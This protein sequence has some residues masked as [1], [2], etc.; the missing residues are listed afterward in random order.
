MAPSFDQ[1]RAA[2]ESGDFSG[3]RSLCL[4]LVESTP[5]AAA[6]QVLAAAE[7]ALGD[8]GAARRALEAAAGLAPDDPGPLIGLA[9][10]DMAEGQAEAAVVRLR[11]VA[12]L[13]EAGP[14]AVNAAGEGL[15]N[16][17]LLVEAESC[18]RRALSDDPSYQA[19]RFNLALARLSSDDPGGAVVLLKEVVR[20]RPGLSPAWLHLGGALNALGRY[21]EAA[22]ALQRSL[23][24]APGNP[25]ALTWLGAAFQHLGEFDE[26]RSQ[27]RA[28]IAAAPNFADAHANLGKLL[29]A[30]GDRRGAADHFRRALDSE[31]G[32]V[33]ARSGLAAWLDNEGRYEEALALL[34]GGEDKGD[35][36]EAAPI[37][38]RILRHMGRPVEAL[39]VLRPALGEP[40]L[41]VD[42]AVQLRF[43]LAAALDA[44]GEYGEAWSTA[45]EANGMRRAGIGDGVVEADLAAMTE[46]V[47][48]LARVFA[49]ADMPNMPRSS[50]L[51]EVPVFIV[52]MPRS[53]KSLVEQVLCSHP[54]VHGAG[55]LTI[56][57]D[58]SAELGRRFGPWPGCA[59]RVETGVLDIMARRC[60]DVITAAAGGGHARVVD[61]M[62]FNFV[63]LGLIEMLFP[64]AR[65]IH[66]VRNPLD[67]ILR[68]YFKNFAGRTLSFAFSLD[69]LVRYFGLYRALMQHWAD[70]SGLRTHLL[71][72]EDLVEDTEGE[73]RRLVAFLGLDWDPACLRY[74]EPGVARSAAPTPVRQPLDDR[75]IGAWKHYEGGLSPIAGR[76]PLEQYDDSGF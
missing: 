18:F 41:G 20:A 69:D 75:E 6:W 7:Q 32:H 21:R 70:A 37:R 34:G 15:G 35:R 36:P 9:R 55:E 5:S 65:I 30:Q 14:A 3:A 57:G 46:A 42:L 27:Y 64:G 66:C 23:A 16:L 58:V 74:Y 2:L 54:G 1:A 50:C 22:E 63:H 40:G 26:A 43:S 56:V 38:A 17:G 8:R 73:A 31:P 39:A 10:L 28:A 53:G 67:L 76:L 52:G 59:P 44:C 60:L 25:L 11:R 19:A 48:G 51:S 61:T 12:A 68:C 45:V 24:L 13:A 47:D 33:H 72:Y 71:R 62:P 49:K 29:Q 4:E